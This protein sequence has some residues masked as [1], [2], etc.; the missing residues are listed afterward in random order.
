[1]F[2]WGIH[3]NHQI[4]ICSKLDRFLRLY[5]FIFLKK[6]HTFTTIQLVAV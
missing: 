6:E 2:E 3:Q 1:M 5:G 4:C